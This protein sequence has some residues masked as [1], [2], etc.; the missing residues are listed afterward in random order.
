MPHRFQPQ[1]RSP[2]DR[3]VGLQSAPQTKIDRELRDLRGQVLEMAELS[4][5]ILDKSLHAVWTRDPALAA[6]VDGDDLA[7]DRLDVEI[8]HAVLQILAL[9]APVATDLRQ[10]LAFKAIATDLERVGDLARNIGGCGRRLAQRVAHP[11]PAELHALADDSRSLLRQAVRS[12]SELDA[13][14]ARHVLAQDD[15]VDELEDRLIRESIARLTADP[16]HTE[17]ELDVIFI[18]KHLERVG[19][20]AT[21]IAEEVV[22]AAEALNLKHSTKLAK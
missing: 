21:N 1:P 10:V 20:H 16:D 14:G 13:E 22:L 9:S 11:L 19:D 3:W 12:L 6:E 5:E 15:L 4:E 17:Q 2:A 7:I 18:A 8:D